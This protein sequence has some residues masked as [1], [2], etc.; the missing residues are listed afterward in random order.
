M[1]KSL[2]RIVAF[3]I[4]II[5]LITFLAACGKNSTSSEQQSNGSKVEAQNTGETYK[6]ED[7]LQPYIIQ[8]LFPGDKPVDMDIV[9]AEVEEQVKD[10]L[11]VK[12]DFQFIPWADYGDKIKIKLAAGDDFDLHLNAPWLNMYQLIAS[13]SIQPWDSYLEKDGQ[14]VLEAFPEEMI[15]AN[16]FDGEIMGIPLGNVLASPHYIA[17]RKDLREKYGMEKPDT[18]DE[19]EQYLRNVKENEKGM[20]PMTWVA[21]TYVMGEKTMLNYI[22]F[23]QNNAGVYIH[24]DE[25]GKV[26]SVA[27]IYEDEKFLRWCRYAHKWYQEGLIQ[28]DVMAQKDEKGAFLSGKA[29]TANVDLQDEATLQSNVPNGTIEYIFFTGE[30]GQSEFVTDFKMW[31]FL[32]LNSRCKDPQRVTKFYNWIFEDQSHYDLLQYGIKDKHWVD[33][34]NHTYDLPEGVNASQNYNFPGYVLLWNPNFD[35]IYAKGSDEYMQVMSFEKETKNFV[36]S[37]LTGFTPNYENIKNELAKVGAIWPETILALG[38]GILDPEK[39]L[40]TIKKKLQSA[41][42]DKIVEEAKRQ[43]AEFINASK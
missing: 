27:P 29:A 30:E 18:L 7:P 23:G 11:N 31:N 38:A 42:Y 8:A 17:I 37:E 16:K 26:E 22:N 3:L 36:R 9:L 24:F 20:I 6:E 1:N 12:L 4:S 32:C 13:S 15:E 21:S 5:M 33:T 40:A 25:Q 19:F 34:G 35:R 41:G 14:A 28:T 10:S 2:L 43:V 39:D